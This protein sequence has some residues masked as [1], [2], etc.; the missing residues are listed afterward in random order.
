METE[1]RYQKRIL[2]V[3]NLLSFFRLGLV[4][5]IFWLYRIR[6][7][8]LMTLWVVILSGVTDLV[9]GFIARRF[10]MTSDLGKA[11]D[12][13]A[14]KLTQT[15]TL[16]CLTARFPH[17]LY[18]LVLLVVKEFFSA[19]AALYTIKKTKEVKGAVWHGKLSTAALYLTLGLHLLWYDIPHALSLITTVGCIG[20]MLLSFVLY[21][22]IYLRDIRS[23]K[24]GK[25]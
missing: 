25:K 21:G 17:M 1:N 19:L 20:M 5:V 22:K 4:P 23:V 15:V 8:Y 12:P 11:L 16:Y 14:D 18:A 9:D 2:T 13:V 24:G 10:H 6:E 7:D 3:P